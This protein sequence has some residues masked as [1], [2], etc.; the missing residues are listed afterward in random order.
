MSSE[1]SSEP[2]PE[3]SPAAPSGKKS[4]MSTCA[5]AGKRSRRVG[6]SCA[7]YCP[8]RC[9]SQCRA[10]RPLPGAAPAAHRL[11]LARAAA[12]L[13]LGRAK[14]LVVVKAQAQRLVLA[15]L[16]VQAQALRLAQVPAAAACRGGRAPAHGIF[17]AAGA[18]GTEPARL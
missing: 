8:W 14:V 5:G 17:A 12:R 11:A 6:A 13:A 3:T 9:S 7:G 2:S 16:R 10:G 1:T 15:R 18:K 4:S